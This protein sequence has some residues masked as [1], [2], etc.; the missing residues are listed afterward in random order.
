MKKI[1]FILLTI[2]LSAG[3]ISCSDQLDIDPNGDLMNAKQVADGA[4]VSKERAEAGVNGI[5]AQMTAYDAIYQDDWQ[6]DFGYPALACWLEHA[7]DN[8]VST[9]HGYNWFARGL[10][11]TGRNKS[12]IG[13]GHD[14][15]WIHMYKYIKLANGIIQTGDLDNINPGVA[16]AY[17]I[18][19]WAYFFLA[20][21][22]QFTYIGNED[23]PCVPIVTEKT[24]EEE[25]N[26]NPRKMVKEVYELILSDLDIATKGLEGYQASAKNKLDQATAYGLRSR[27]YMVMNQW[28]KAAADAQKAIDL[29]S[30]TPFT[31]EDCSIP[32][33]DDVQEAKNSMWGIIITGEDDVTKT[34][35]CN[36][37]SM[38]TSLCF[39]SGGYTT[40]VGTYKMINTLLY[41]EIP[42]SDV[43]KGWW[44][45][46]VQKY[47]D[48]KPVVDEEGNPVII[49]K[50]PL[51][52]NAYPADTTWL[53]EELLP[54]SVVKF[55]PNKKSLTDKENATDFPLMR[56]EEMYYNLAESKAMSGN[57]A[58]GKKIL[59]EF[60][61]QYRD[62]KFKSNATDAKSLQDEIYNQKRVEFWG[63]GI[64]WFDM[65]RLKKGVNRVDV[66]NK[67]TGGYPELTRFNLKHDDPILIYQIPLSEEQAN[68]GLEGQNNPPGATPEDLL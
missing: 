21:T 55:A 35:I 30:A 64:S 15:S 68:K 19:A 3:I 11:Y 13:R 53:F 63:E 18:R 1:K 27:V 22:F 4:K 28:D 9:T 47:K 38:F 44:A 25:L 54:F 36:F 34:G 59:E 66:V 65:M 31:I 50:S 33:F 62:P 32:N 23:K 48:G 17:A 12:Q 42:D 67:K 43:R 56:V 10:R 41:D 16:Q 39:G 61:K 51:L 46:P 57:F 40:M 20:Q 29:T 49:A 8:V 45:A 6:S 60:V 2:G 24:T 52:I 7:G 58:E 37:T 14:F 26:N 5:F